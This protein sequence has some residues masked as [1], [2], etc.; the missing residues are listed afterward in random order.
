MR[1]LICSKS[2]H[3]GW[4]PFQ[5]QRKGCPAAFPGKDGG[6]RRFSKSARARSDREVEKRW[7]R[8]VANRCGGEPARSESS[9]RSPRSCV[10]R[11]KKA[12]ARNPD[13]ETSGEAWKRRVL[14]ADLS[15]AAARGT[16]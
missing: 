11:M 4:C 6:G 9:D 2:S 1:C 15:P 5:I 3:M 14:D 8:T 13:P 7:A 16:R 12:A 10:A